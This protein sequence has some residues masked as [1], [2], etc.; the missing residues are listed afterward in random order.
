MVKNTKITSN[1][2]ESIKGAIG[3]NVYYREAITL[4]K[5][6]NLQVLQGGSLNSTETTIIWSAVPN[7]MHYRVFYKNEL[8]ATVNTISYTFHEELND[9]VKIQAYNSVT[10]S[11]FS[12]NLYVY[13]VPNKP[14]S[15]T[16]SYTYVEGQGYAFV[17]NFIDNSYMENEYRVIY[18]TDDGDFNTIIVEA[19]S[20]VGTQLTTRFATYDINNKIV[21]R[22]ISAN[23]I[24]NNEMGEIITLYKTAEPLWLYDIQR[25]RVKFTSKN[26]IPGVDKYEIKYKY[27]EADEYQTLQINLNKKLEINEDLVHYLPLDP[28]ATVYLSCVS[29]NG[30][31]KH[32]PSDVVIAGEQYDTS[33]VA[34]REFEYEWTSDGQ[35]TLSWRDKGSKSFRLEQTLNNI[36]SYITIPALDITDLDYTNEFHKFTCLIDYTKYDTQIDSSFRVCSIIPSGTDVFYS[37]YTNTL[38]I[39]YVNTEK[40]PPRWVNKATATNGNVRFEWEPLEFVDKYVFC[41][42]TTSDIKEVHE[43]YLN[44][45][46][47]EVPISRIET[48][49]Y[50]NYLRA[51]V[52]VRYVG[53]FVSEPTEEILFKPYRYTPK[54][55]FNICNSSHC[56]SL[57]NTSIYSKTRNEYPIG[58]LSIN[59]NKTSNTLNT[60]F[61]STLITKQSPLEL[62]SY[63]SGIR[64]NGQINS[65]VINEKAKR[66]SRLE[67]LNY[68]KTTKNT[69]IEET[70]RTVSSTEYFIHEEIN[71][72]RIVCIGDSL[73]S[74]H[75]GYYAETNTGDPRHC[76]E[77]WLNRRLKGAYQIINKGYGSDTTDQI[78]DRFDRDV[79][80]SHPQY[81][82]IQGGTNDL[83]WAQANSN[84]NQTALDRDVAVTKNNIIS[85]I[86]KCWDN[87]IHP[88]IGN[89]LVRTGVVGTIYGQALYDYNNWLKNWCIENNS[90][91]HPVTYWDWFNAGKD[92]IPATPLEDPTL[93]GAMNPIYDGDAIFDTYGNIV[94]QG[95]GIH[96]NM[97]GYRILAESLNLSTFKTYDSGFKVYR[98]E[99]CTIEE[100]FNSDDTLNPFYTVSIDN[101][102][103][104]K[105]KTIVR[106]VKNIGQK[107]AL[108]ALYPIKISSLDVW[109]NVKVGDKMV[110]QSFVSGLSTPDMITKV[111]IE[112]M[113]KN[114]E[115]KSSL[116]LSLAGREFSSQS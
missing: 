98:D 105:K 32:L 16:V 85:M 33:L 59:N 97:D 27:N 20:G 99:K 109:F 47:Y 51:Y 78:L 116:I 4:E 24:G 19:G 53:G 28:S 54:L 3:V 10:E 61:I 50:N 36:T 57:F 14:L 115:S 6:K 70:I 114:E 77:Y 1:I 87:N 71:L 7:A 68:Y 110:K 111:T 31:I 49:V 46:Y 8:V 56:D 21:I 5:P 69:N 91:Q 92:A 100:T 84:G 13:T 88:V 76:Y 86:Q 9:N 25:N 35:I 102:R 67:T 64:Y 41:L 60:L 55:A 72:V 23:T 42:E 82:I 44:D 38:S 83:Y 22:I 106:Y 95:R 81:A 96:L 75:P 52:K 26:K 12:D 15:P 39:V 103:R 94:K 34:P 37:E 80:S 108:F 79:L 113:V 62:D 93:P 66:E 101:I 112:M 90:E 74:G 48:G 17:V 63:G 73:T 45:N 18:Q 2:Y 11:E 29:Y 104:G 40:I 65:L 43:T 58:Q 89:L 107:Q 30:Q